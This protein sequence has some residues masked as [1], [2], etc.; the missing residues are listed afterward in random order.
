[1][2]KVIRSGRDVPVVDGEP[3]AGA[4]EAGHHLV[5]DVDDAV[6]VADLAHAGQVAVRRDEDAG[7]ARDATPARCAAIV[8][9]PSNA[10][11]CS[12]CSS[13][14]S[15]SCSSDSRPERRAVGVRAEE[16]HDAGGAAV[17]GPAP[18]VAGHLDRGGRVAVVAAVGREHLVPAGVQPG[19]PHRVLD[20]V[21]A[22][23][24]EEHLVAARRARARRSAGRPRSARRWR[25]A[26]RWC[27]AGRPA[28]GSR[29]RPWGAGGRC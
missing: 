19:H 28:P 5:G 25:A 18:R 12:R 6:A 23:V 9:G 10:T 8:P 1:M 20:R 16:V 26:A 17:V 21:G 14:R 3:L 15:H 27:R 7:R 13:A 4:A 29:R 2:A 11:T 22:A 24:G